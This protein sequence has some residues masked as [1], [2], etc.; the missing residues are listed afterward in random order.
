MTRK[1]TIF[2]SAFVIGLS[3]AMMPGPLLSA[4]IGY[5]LK[6][7]FLAGGPLIVLGHGLLEATLVVL[8]LVGLGKVLARKSVGA[9]IGLVGGAVLLWMGYGMA[10][11]AVGGGGVALEGGGQPLPASPVV[12]GI[13]VSLANPYWTLWWATI[14]LKYI[15]LS[16]EAGKLG[17]AAFCSGH[18]LSDA[19]WY[20]AVAGAVALGRKAIP[21]AAYRWIIG[22]CGVVLVGFGVWFIAAGIRHF[23]RGRKQEDAARATCD[24]PQG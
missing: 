21:Q 7:G 12:A 6:D 2:G 10:A 4:S 23:V 17:A 24:V 11:F 22:G 18:I 19:A 9:G 3:G 5:T 20:L 15:A 1:W 16:R 13:L 14:G 8:V